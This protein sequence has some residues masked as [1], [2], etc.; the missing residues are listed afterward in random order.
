ML[1]TLQIKEEG[2]FGE[3]SGLRPVS[4]PKGSSDTELRSCV[5]AEGVRPI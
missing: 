3:V 4:E 2:S 1:T 5:N